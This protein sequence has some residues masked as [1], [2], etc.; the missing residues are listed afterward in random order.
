MPL[1]HIGGRALVLAHSLRGCSVYLQDGF[2]VERVLEAVERERISTTQVVPTMV[3]RLLDHPHLGDRDLTSLRRIW[4][5]SAPMPVELLRRA[6]AAFGPMFL[7]GYGQTEAGPLVSAMQ[8]HEHVLEGPEAVRLASCGRPVPGVEVR[9]IGDNGQQLPACQVGEI[10][11]RSP[12][13]MM[14][15]WEQPA[16][17]LEALRDGRLRTGDMAYEDEDGYIYIVDRKRD[18]IISGGENVYP[19][20]V[21]EVLYGHPAVLEASVIGV[22][23]EVWGESVK[24]LLVRRAGMEATESELIEYCKDRL[25]GYKRPKSIEFKEVLPKTASGKVLK[26]ALREVYWQEQSR[27]V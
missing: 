4:Y 12:F 17:T 21:E 14:E 22:P 16:Q 1:Y 9:I 6:L 25:A 11:V 18:M 24:A 3:A 15:Y 19:R 8:P 23:D 5:A 13:L 26:R 20:E 27:R 10:E 7:Q 2:E